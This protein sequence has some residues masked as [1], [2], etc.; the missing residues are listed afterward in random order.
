VT[1]RAAAS[2][3]I[4]LLLMIALVSGCI[5]CGESLWPNEEKRARKAARVARENREMRRVAHR[6]ALKVQSQIRRGLVFGASDAADCDKRVVQPLQPVEGTQVV[7][8]GNFGAGWPLALEYGFLRCEHGAIAGRP[9]R[10][11]VF[12]TPDG[13]DYALSEDAR[14]VGYP[15]IAPIFGDNGEPRYRNALTRAGLRLCEA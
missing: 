14:W 7:A 2:R 9:Q 4:G 1:L 11:V 6:R 13:T 8:C 15:P 3:A 5:G 12:T 10:R